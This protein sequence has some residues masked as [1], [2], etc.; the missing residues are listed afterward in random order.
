MQKTQKLQNTEKLI[1]LGPDSPV[2]R[3]V[4]KALESSGAAARRFACASF[5]AAATQ[6]D[7]VIL[8][9]CYDRG[10]QVV[11]AGRTGQSG[12][13][14]A[15]CD[16]EESAASSIGNAVQSA[17]GRDPGQASISDNA[18]QSAADCDPGQASIP[19]WFEEV[20]EAIGRLQQSRPCRVLFVSDTMVYG[21]VYGEQHLL[22]E[23]E[24]GYV[25]H[26]SAKDRTA[27]WMRMA[28]HLCAR[29]AREEGLAV[30]IARVDWSEFAEEPQRQAEALDR[31]LN[32]MLSILER[33]VAGEAYNLS[34]LTLETLAGKNAACAG[35]RSP[36]SPVAVIPDIGKAEN[37]AAS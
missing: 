13:S 21:K 37:Y 26:T 11:A 5:E 35:A 4:R 22:R 17:A 15:G 29:L 14:A 33:G 6:A 20:A 9:G 16:S 30:K 1:L 34:S 10:G 32:R 25:C 19:Q 3:L 12:S 8:F 31:L 7:S 36:L 2:K 27:Q 18:V 24:T 23:D 28:E